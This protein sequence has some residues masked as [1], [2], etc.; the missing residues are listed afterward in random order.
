M[1][2]IDRYI[3]KEW[4]VAFL[5]TF[6]LVV[7]VLILHN[8]LDKLPDLFQAQ[9]TFLQIL[10]YISLTLPA[11]LTLVLPIIFLVSLLFAVGNL[12]R[13][14]EIIALRAQGVSLLR[15]CR[16]LWVV[17]FLLSMGLFYLTAFLV[18]QTVERSRT[19]YDQL[20]YA[21]REAVMESHEIGLIYNMGFDN[22]Q[23][24]R[25]WFMDRFSE[26]AWLALGINVHIRDTEGHESQR[27]S[28]SEAYYDD[29]QGNWIFLNGRELLLDPVTGDPLRIIP[30][31][32]KVF[33]EFTEDPALMLALYKR[34]KELSLHEIHKIIK[35]IPVEDNPAVHAYLVRYFQQL[36]SPFTCLIMVGIAVPFAATGVR[37]S[38]MVGISK[39]LA[40]FAGFFLL[41]NI[42]TL[43]GERQI[44]PAWMAAGLPIFAMIFIA[45]WLFKRAA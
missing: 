33:P 30:F 26:R 45:D 27:I 22:R 38:P 35:T 13:N 43:L 3:L 18:P 11:Y 32:Q 42:A 7:G 9:A 14:N 12:H 28:A 29:T 31:E 24:G 6:S 4:L 20:D 23:N 21:A 25:L 36:A 19:F 37:T 41:I 15:I 44:I 2:L 39:S 10:Y 34:P 40:F 8:M 17:G 16:S 5:L 1:L